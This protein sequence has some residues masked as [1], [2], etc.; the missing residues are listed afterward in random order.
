MIIVTGLTYVGKTTIM[1]QLKG[2]LKLSDVEKYSTS[3]LDFTEQAQRKTTSISKEEFE[4]LQANGFFGWVK[5]NPDGTYE[6]IAK[7]EFADD[8]KIMEVDFDT[9]KSME[10][11]I[12]TSAKTVYVEAGSRRRYERAI[13]KGVPEIMVFDAM[14]ADN[15]KEP[16]VARGI[17]VNNS[18][19]DGGE[20]AATNVAYSLSEY[21][22][23]GVVYATRI[24]PTTVVKEN[25]YTAPKLCRFLGFEEEIV[26]KAREQYDTN[27]PEGA[28]AANAYYIEE[29]KQYACIKYTPMFYED[30]MAKD[31]QDVVV[32]VGGEHYHLFD[33]DKPNKAPYVKTLTKKESN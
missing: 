16:G 19:S 14:H 5:T 12:P 6:G 33:G 27:T 18:I 31:P 15:F 1:N 32:T 13:E 22:E 30:N 28:A 25:E 7:T 29:M 3:N 17:R 11:V 8:T 20:F 21:K 26:A 10:G 23:F 24:P 2:T 9:Y 4:A